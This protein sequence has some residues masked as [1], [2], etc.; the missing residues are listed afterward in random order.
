MDDLPPHSTYYKAYEQ[1]NQ[2]T[3]NN[4]LELY[5]EKTVCLN[6][7]LE[8]LRTLKA[9]SKYTDRFLTI[10]SLL[11]ARCRFNQKRLGILYNSDWM[12]FTAKAPGTGRHGTKCNSISCATV[13]N[14]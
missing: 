2:Q 14:G 1:E 7:E 5:T 8:M 3:D 13:R 12:N 9:L 10:F 11:D 4:L 6:Y